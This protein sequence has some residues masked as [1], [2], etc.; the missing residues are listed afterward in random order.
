[1]I[2]SREGVIGLP[3]RLTVS[4]M[5]LAIM[6]PPILESVGNIQDGIEAERMSDCGNELAGMLKDV[7]SKGPGYRTWGQLDIPDGG[8]L[9]IGG[10]DGH[11]IRVIAN[12]E[13]TGSILLPR[14]VAGDETVLSGSVL[15]ELS[16][17]ADG[18]RVRTL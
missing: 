13:R 8:G 4:F 2:P 15:L 7:G 14:P 11:I 1:M 6:V 18:V 5:I 10:A 9:A 17:D 3:I 16:N 12:G